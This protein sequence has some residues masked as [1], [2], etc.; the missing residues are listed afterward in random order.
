MK[1]NQIT[2]L[3]A[4]ILILSPTSVILAIISTEHFHIGSAFLSPIFEATALILAVMIVVIIITHI[5]AELM[6]EPH[7]LSRLTHIVRQL[8]M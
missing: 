1:I 8:L 3:L 5:I 4:T 6:P 7:L 2:S